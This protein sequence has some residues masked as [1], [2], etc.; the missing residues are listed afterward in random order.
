MSTRVDRSRPPALGTP[1]PPVIP[2]IRRARL[3]SGVPVL[4]A[5]RPALPVVDVRLVVR[6]GAALDPPGLEGVAALAAAALDEGI[7]SH[8]GPALAAALARIGASYRAW[9]DWHDTTLSLHVLTPQLRTALELFAGIARAPTFPEDAV[10]RR[11]AQRAA[12]LRQDRD[13]PAVTASRA[14]SRAIYAPH[15]Y[16]IGPAGTPECVEVLEHDEIVRAYTEHFGPERA[17]IVAAGDV[18]LESLV[19]MLDELFGDWQGGAPLVEPAPPPADGATVIHVIDRPDAPQSELR[20]GHPGP[21]RSTSDYFPLVVGNTILGGAFTSRI[22]L[23]L[24]EQ[25][26]LTYGARTGFAFRRAG[27]PFAASVAIQTDATAEAVRDIL[28][29]MD[30]MR[31]SAPRDD[32]IDRARS[33]LALGLPRALETAG[34]LADRVADIEDH[35][36]PDDY[37]ARYLDHIMA[38]TPDQVRAAATRHLQPEKAA[39]VVVGD[40]ERVREPLE[41]LG[42][43]RVE[44]QDAP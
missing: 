34:A 7:E 25:K 6:G 21:P 11:R 24:R 35:G 30:A 3:R 20:V 2:A 8:D 14:I 27:G 1:I 36:L 39:I 5:E 29:A 40:L 12:S 31:A 23:V 41:H 13:E 43:A 28:D 37:L 33:Y 42:L 9:V 10:A 38:V 32:E 26:G 16:G 44:V 4:L 22:N 19:P 15:R 18:T 17:F